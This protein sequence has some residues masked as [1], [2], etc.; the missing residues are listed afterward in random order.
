MQVHLVEASSRYSN[1]E[2]D[3][4]ED[5]AALQHGRCRSRSSSFYLRED[6]ALEEDCWGAATFNPATD[7]KDGRHCPP[8]Q[9]SKQ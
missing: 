1:G 9:R 5:I 2:D 3:E 4:E 6:E 8:A 7:D